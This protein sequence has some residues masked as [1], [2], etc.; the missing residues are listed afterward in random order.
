MQES[1]EQTGEAVEAGAGPAEGAAWHSPLE[2]D[3]VSPV[4]SSGSALDPQL[5]RSALLSPLLLPLLLQL[6]P[7]H[8]YLSSKVVDKGV[9]TWVVSLVY[10]PDGV[11]FRFVCCL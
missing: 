1:G 9:S 3:P 8:A 11:T 7:M 4:S 2:G 6:C 5:Y 10:N